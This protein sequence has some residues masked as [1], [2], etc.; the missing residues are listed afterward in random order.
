MNGKRI[1][2]GADHERSDGDSVV[3]RYLLVRRSGSVRV[4]RPPS[5]K[6]IVARMRDVRLANRRLLRATRTFTDFVRPAGIE[7]R[8][9]PMRTARCRPRRTVDSTTL[10]RQRAGPRQR[11]LSITI[12]RRERRAIRV[13]SAARVRRG[14]AAGAGGGGAGGDGGG[15]ATCIGRVDS[16]AET[17]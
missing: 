6:V 17:R 5:R 1:R 7:N 2:S 8:R 12:P 11:I 10:P 9:A 13:E 4:S 15:D 3:A 16:T 14:L